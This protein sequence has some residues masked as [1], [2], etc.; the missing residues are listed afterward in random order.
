MTTTPET[1]ASNPHRSKLDGSKETTRIE[2]N[3]NN[4][5][6]K[7]ATGLFLILTIGIFLFKLLA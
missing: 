2:I 5:S 1:I 4:I 3:S 7:V 6:S